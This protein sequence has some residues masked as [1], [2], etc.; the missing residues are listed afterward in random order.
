MIKHLILA[1]VL[2]VAAFCCSASSVYADSV[3][4]TGGTISTLGGVSSVSLTG[5]NFSIT[6]SGEI[7]QGMVTS[8]GFN[9]SSVGF[10]SPLVISNGVS[11]TF[12]KGSLAF[13]DSSLSG[14]LVAYG[15]LADL[16]LNQN[17]L[18]NVT[19]T[20]GGYMTQSNVNGLTQTQFSVVTPTSVPEPSTLVLL[21]TGGLGLVPL[22][23]RLR[24]RKH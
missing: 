13:T 23:Y 3:T 5:Q 4:L 11:S 1:L 21:L 10:G 2:G 6:Y 16:F 14:S 9:T 17:A 19:F 7:P 20:G 15:S 12:F 8:F 24:N 18:F 22:K